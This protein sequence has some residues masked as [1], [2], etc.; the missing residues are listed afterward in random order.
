M[1]KYFSKFPKVLYN[2]E[3]NNVDVIT[4]ITVRFALEKKLKE[5]TITYFNYTIRD[6]DTPEIIASKLYD[7]PEAHWI[8][9]M[10]NDIL[11]IEEDWPLQYNALN[12][13]VER[14]YSTPEYADTANTDVS[15]I[16]WAQQN[17]Q[18]YYKVI[19]TISPDGTENVKELQ[20]DEQSYDGMQVSQDQKTLSDGK[21]ITIKVSKKTKSYYDY[22]NDLNESKRIIKI[23]K[24]EFVAGLEEELR[25]L[26]NE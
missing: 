23:L 9:M 14:K 26:F 15:G 17:E 11:D 3:G 5:N 24:P 13:F 19:T 6:G 7:N 10:L 12:R 25:V 16:I 1:A 2:F 18:S 21:T 4:N 22:E 8:I 20:I